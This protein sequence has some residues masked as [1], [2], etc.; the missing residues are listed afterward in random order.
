MKL[1]SCR[2]P[3]G[4]G[5]PQMVDKAVRSHMDQSQPWGKDPCP[6]LSTALG[7]SSV[8]AL[9]WITAFGYMCHRDVRTGSVQAAHPGTHQ[10]RCSTQLRKALPPVPS[11]KAN[12]IPA[13]SV[14]KQQW[15]HSLWPCSTSLL[16]WP[17]QVHCLRIMY[18]DHL[19]NNS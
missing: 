3:Y 18:P 2:S 5:A 16:Q 11:K 19:F 13:G 17:S 12:K 9:S 14:Y 15:P 6:T 1:E 4:K 8:S 7:A 10:R